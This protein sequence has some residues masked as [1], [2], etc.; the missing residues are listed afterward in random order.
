M[1]YLLLAVGKWE[2]WVLRFNYFSITYTPVLIAGSP[3]YT[4]GEETIAVLS[5]LGPVVPRGHHFCLMQD[6]E[7]IVSFHNKALNLS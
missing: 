5:N 7:L 4:E 1:K 3:S 2:Y 6:S